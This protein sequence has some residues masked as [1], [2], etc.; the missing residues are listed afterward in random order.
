MT[1]KGCR[2]LLAVNRGDL[3]LGAGRQRRVEPAAA[4]LLIIDQNFLYHPSCRYSDTWQC[5]LAPPGNTISTPVSAGE[6]LPS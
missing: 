3:A 6:R 1:A 4:G 5:P 2:A